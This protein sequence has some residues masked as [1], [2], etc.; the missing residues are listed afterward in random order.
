MYIDDSTMA[1]GVKLGDVTVPVLPTMGPHGRMGQ[2]HL[3]IPGDYTSLQHRLWD[4]H[5]AASAQ[6]MEL[7]TQENNLAGF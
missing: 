2:S 1:E 7:N 4:I 6:G 3:G 5:C